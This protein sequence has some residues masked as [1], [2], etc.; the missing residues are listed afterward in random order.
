MDISN[1]IVIA[2]GVAAIAWVNWYFFVAGRRTP[3]R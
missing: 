3:K 2:A 1:W